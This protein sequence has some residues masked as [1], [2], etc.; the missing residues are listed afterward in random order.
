M[1]FFDD[2]IINAGAPG[3][4]SSNLSL[5]AVAK[6]AA[7]AKKRKY[8]ADAEELLGFMT[9]LIHSI[10]CV[11]C[12]VWTSQRHLASQLAANWDRPY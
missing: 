10:D 11:A 2:R 7:Q 6:R 5:E 4:L 12:Q 3:L 9:P 1:A 8:S